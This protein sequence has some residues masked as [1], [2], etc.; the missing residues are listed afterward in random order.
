MCGVVLCNFGHVRLL[1]AATATTTP[2]KT[3]FLTEIQK[4]SLNMDAGDVS[5]EDVESLLFLATRVYAL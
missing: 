5:S 3:N 1:I 2:T 4:Q